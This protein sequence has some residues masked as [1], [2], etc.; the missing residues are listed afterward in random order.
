MVTTDRTARRPVQVGGVLVVAA[1]VMLGST[2]C[3]PPPGTLTSERSKVSVVRDERPGLVRIEGIGPIRGFAK[4]RDSTFMHCLELVLE[5]TGR[6]L[7]YDELMGVSGLAFRI[8]F[9]NDRW[10]VGNPDPLVGADCVASLFAAIGWEY[11]TWVVRLDEIAEANSLRQAINQSIDRGIPVLAANIIP[12]EDWGLIVGYRPDRSWLCR[13]YNGG[14]ERVDQPH[15]GWPTAVVILNK[16]LARPDPVK[17]HADSIRRAIELFDKKSTG[18][19][20]LGAKAFDDWC[21]NL[22]TV[23]NEKYVHANFWTYIGLIDARAAAVRYL[24]SIAKEFGPKEI[25]LNLAADQ[26]DKE[27]QR[28]LKGIGD[29]PSAQKYPDSMP[30]KEMRDHQIDALRDAQMLEKNAIESLRKA[31]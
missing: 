22:R 23:R 28:L 16:R 17:A 7:G 30:P 19:Y 13:S 24:R 8:Q 26:Y 1:A 5:A 15:K 3:A 18:S 2:G 12:P 31:L 4:G 14:A 10:D 9:C 6:P 21:Q 25:H 29:V 11:E 20:S 27:V